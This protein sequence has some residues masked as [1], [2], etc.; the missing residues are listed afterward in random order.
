MTADGVKAL[1]DLGRPLVR[2]GL[3]EERYARM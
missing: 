1:A 2:G 3:A